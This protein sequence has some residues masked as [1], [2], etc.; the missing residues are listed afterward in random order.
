MITAV[1]DNPCTW[2]REAWANG[3]LVASIDSSLMYHKGFNGW[4]DMPFMLNCGR[5][6]DAGTIRGNLGAIP[7]KYLPMLAPRRV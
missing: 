2:R 3:R 5:N 4:S 7:I 1:Y 6:F